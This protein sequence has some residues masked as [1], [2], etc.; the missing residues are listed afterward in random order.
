VEITEVL[1]HGI[2]TEKSVLLQAQNKYTFKVALEANK[3]EIRRAVETLFNVNVVSVNT[4]RMP[5][6][7][8]RMYRRRRGSAARTKEAREWKKAV[9]TLREGQTIDALKA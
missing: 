9:V 1:R 7:S 8:H 4:M 2:V 5:G 6:K 3:I